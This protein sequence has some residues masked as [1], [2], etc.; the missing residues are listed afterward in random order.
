MKSLRALILIAVFAAAFT[1]SFQ[2][3]SPPPIVSVFLGGDVWK[4]AALPDLPVFNVDGKHV[5]LGLRYN[6]VTFLDLPLIEFSRDYVG[7]VPGEL[8][9]YHDLSEEQLR[10]VTEVARIK[11]KPAAE[12]D[13][14]YRRAQRVMGL[15]LA[16]TLIGEAITAY[17]TRSLPFFFFM[18]P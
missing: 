8:F 9:R 17:L 1:V 10:A 16:I 14:G 5:D 12:I 3:D 13:P 7:Y 15:I 4:V 6:N 11:L 2:K 18:V